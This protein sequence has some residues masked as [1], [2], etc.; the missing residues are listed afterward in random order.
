M[1]Y[2]GVAQIFIDRLL[3]LPAKSRKTNSDQDKF[4]EKRTMPMIDADG[5]PIHVEVEGPDGAPALM[6]SNSLGTDLSMWDP[7]AK[8]F[9]EKFRLI[10]YDRRGHGQSGAPKG[11]YTMERLG[12]DVLAV[13]D[14]LKIEKTHWCGLSMGG[15]VGQWLGAN[16]PRTHGPHDP[17]EH[18]LLLRRQGDLERPHQVAA[19]ER[20]SRNC[21]RN[22]GAL[23]HAGLSRARAANHRKHERDP[24]EDAARRLYRL[25]RSDR[26]TWIIARC[27]RRSKRRS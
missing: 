5:C 3:A 2:Q 19:R 16:A 25:L 14:A 22:H 24:A 18:G 13:L 23:V 7:Q 6:L 9:A 17:V 12:R 1:S 27:S 11:P 21:R 10:R 8:A 26:A 20:P 15:M 4:R